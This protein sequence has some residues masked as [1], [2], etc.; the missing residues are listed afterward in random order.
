M[1]ETNAGSGKTKMPLHW[2][3]AIGFVAG[4]MAKT[5]DMR[6]ETP[7][8]TMGI[9][10]TA[11]LVEISSSD[12]QTRFSV[13][14]EP[15]GTTGSFNLYNKTTG[16]LIAT[17]SSSQIGWLVSPAGPLQVVAEQF[18]KSPAQLQQELGIVQQIFT[19]FN[20]NQQ[21]PFV[22]PQQPDNQERRGDAPNDSNPQT[23]QGPG[24]SGEAFNNGSTTG[25]VQVTQNGQTTTFNVT[26]TPTSTTATTD[27]TD[28]SATP[29]PDGGAAT[30]LS[31]PPPL[32]VIDFSQAS[33]GQT[34]T[35][36]EDADQI[37][38]SNFDDSIEAN[39]GDD[40]V[41]A[42]GGNDTIIAAHGGGRI[43]SASASISPVR[44]RST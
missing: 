24:G 4:Q 31:S 34:I 1:T 40:L 41:F 44:M 39:G 29:T 3:M 21:N 27:P 25:T 28:T 33:S 23:A 5:G 42:G 20:N 37:F 12:G 6:V 10:G 32:N 36:G 11:V 16:G 19:I 22:P 43:H 18:Q 14:V 38:G 7:V 8:A 30:P 15:D 35:G 26:V 13:M 17:V 9:R 2:K